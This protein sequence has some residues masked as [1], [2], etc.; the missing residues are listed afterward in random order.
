MEW[1]KNGRELTWEKNENISEWNYLILL[2]HIKYLWSR[3]KSHTHGDNHLKGET[4]KWTKKFIGK[5]LASVDTFTKSVFSSH[6]FLSTLPLFSSLFF[7]LSSSSS[8]MKKSLPLSHHLHCVHIVSFSIVFLPLQNCMFNVCS[9][10]SLK[11]NK[12][13]PTVSNYFCFLSTCPNGDSDGQSLQERE[14]ERKR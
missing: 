2:Y 9:F 3:S 14:R 11:V 12:K 13:A 10:Q 6:N 5:R 4:K 8:V 1:W 7:F